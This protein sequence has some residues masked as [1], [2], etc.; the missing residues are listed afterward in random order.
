LLSVI[1]Y[2]RDFLEFLLLMNSQQL[3]HR[4]LLFTAAN[5]SHRA[6]Q[7]VIDLRK[8]QT[9]ISRYQH[10]EMLFLVCAFLYWLGSVL[11]Q[12]NIAKVVQ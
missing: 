9:L 5:D 2:V 4:L 7:L 11:L 1:A 8:L 6:R 10:W 3:V 12:S